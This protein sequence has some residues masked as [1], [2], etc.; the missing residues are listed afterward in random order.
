M[1]YAYL[2]CHDDGR[3]ALPICNPI[4]SAKLAA[5]DISNFFHAA[6]HTSISSH[7]SSLHHHDTIICMPVLVVLTSR[8]PV[9]L[10][11]QW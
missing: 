2:E 5:K 7:M 6:G 4:H 10:L 1:L 8:Q 9:A 3:Q 11:S